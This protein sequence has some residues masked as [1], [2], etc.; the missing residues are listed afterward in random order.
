MVGHSPRKGYRY[1][2]CHRHTGDYSGSKDRC[3]AKYV[4][5]L[6]IEETVWNK[7]REALLE[8][9]RVL[10]GARKH[11]EEMLASAK[12]LEQV[13]LA[14]ETQVSQSQDKLARLL[15]LHLNGNINQ[16][17]YVVKKGE[18][19][20]TMKRLR[21]EQGKVRER[22]LEQQFIPEET[23]TAIRHFAA[24]IAARLNDEWPDS[25][26]MTLY[27][28]LRLECVY[29]YTTGEL[30]ISGLLSVMSRCPATS[31]AAAS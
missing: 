4:P 18:I 26:K 1:Y 10:I 8:P 29:N 15:D 7:V 16:E 11:R 24:E 9:D 13:I 30:V 20:A 21:D 31:H 2:I 27:D 5:A 17:Q 12:L 19:E 22:M 23:E 14:L 6:G 25:E 3:S 28:L